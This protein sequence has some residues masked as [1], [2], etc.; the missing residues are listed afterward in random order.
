MSFYA[1]YGSNS[2][3]SSEPPSSMSFYAL[4]GSKNK[5]ATF[6][7]FPDLN[8]RFTFHLKNAEP[9]IPNVSKQQYIFQPYLLGYGQ[10]QAGLE[11]P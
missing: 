11:K 3:N 9:R 4:Y 5:D 7:R 2:S 1:L 6:S 10:K 8:L